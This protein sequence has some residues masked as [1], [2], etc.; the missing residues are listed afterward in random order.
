MHDGELRAPPVVV[1]VTTSCNSN[2]YGK[3]RHV[4]KLQSMTIGGRELKGTAREVAERMQGTEPE[5]IDEWFTE[6][7]GVKYPVKQVLAVYSGWPRTF[8]S[9]DAI[10][11]LHRWGFDAWRSSTG[12]YEDHKRD[13]ARPT[14]SS[15]LSAWALEPPN[16]M[17]LLYHAWAEG[18]TG[19]KLDQ[20]A[21]LVGMRLQQAWQEHNRE[22]DPGTAE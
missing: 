21:F 11:F 14:P 6:I 22:S 3:V 13:S 4:D 8:T 5:R 18:V 12:K 15:D 17:Q 20:V 16:Q 1:T 7:G 2:Y 10:R 9:A 19:R